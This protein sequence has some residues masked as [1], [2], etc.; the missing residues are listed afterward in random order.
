MT[1]IQSVSQNF[2]QFL[3]SNIFYPLGMKDTGFSL[4]EE[5][6]PQIT[7]EGVIKRCV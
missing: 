6:S 5:C 1:K 3:K 2:E 7:K 4:N